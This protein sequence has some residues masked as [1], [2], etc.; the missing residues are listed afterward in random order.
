MNALSHWRR[1]GSRGAFLAWALGGALALALAGCHKDEAPPAMP[2]SLVTAATAVAKDVPLYLD[3]IGQMTSYE[4]V[5]IV[6]QVAGQIVE[7]PFEQGAIVKKGDLLVK[8][9]QPPFVAAVQKEQGLVQSDE[10]NL[11]LAKLQRERSAPLLPNNLV[12]KQQYDTYVAQVQAA[13]GQL[14]ADQADLLTAQIDLDFSMIRAPVD[15]MVGTYQINIGNVVKVNDAAITTIQQMD[16]MYAD[17]IVSGTDFPQV[18][19]YFD[20]SAGNLTVEVSSLANPTQHRDGYLTI[21]GNNIATSTGTVT[22]RATLPNQDRLFWPNEPIKVRILMTTLPQAVLVPAEA[23]Q[24]SQQGQF[25]FVVDDPKQPG[26][27]LTVEQRVVQVGQA[28]E[29]GLVVITSGL[30]AGEK[31]VVR[32]QLFLQAGF[33]VTIA[34]LDGKS[35]LPNADTGAGAPLPGQG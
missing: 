23:V 30:K 34:E 25:L 10:A 32:N 35:L 8:I 16:P 29:D 24:L 9:Y 33:P 1:I 20:Q 3:T 27:P 19:Q 14:K 28:Q 6:S 11:A 21:L 31:V 4:S 15:G 17:F 5:N 2:P 12:S 22:V 18:R 13:D 7:M 26:Q